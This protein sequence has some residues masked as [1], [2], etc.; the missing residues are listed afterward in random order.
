MSYWV[1]LVNKEEEI[2]EVE[3]FEE[4]GTY[5]LGGSTGADLNITYNYSK[6]YA[7]F[8]FSLWDL[9]GK[10]AKHTVA[11]LEK[12]VASLGIEKSRDYWEATPGNAGYALSILLR[13]A[14]QHPRTKWRVH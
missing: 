11:T 2:V 4:G 10:R 13:W 6:Q 8:G 14:Q 12:L 3:S 9:E 5:C 1:S 7:R